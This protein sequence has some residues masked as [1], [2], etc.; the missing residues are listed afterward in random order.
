MTDT[1]SPIHHD[2]T[3]T[4]RE[5]IE[6]TAFARH[7]VT[8]YSAGRLRRSTLVQLRWAAV[9]GQ[10]L[11]MAIVWFGLGFTLP[12]I[13]CAATIGTSAVLNLAL[14][15][16]A[17]LDRRVSDKEALAQLAFDSLQLAALLWLTGGLDNPFALLFLAPVVTSATTLRKR[18]L[19]SLAALTALLAIFLMY[20]SLPLPWYADTDFTL[21]PMFKI[22]S[23]TALMT[24]MAFTSLYAWGASLEQRRMSDALAATEAVLA[25]EQKLAALGGLAAA[26]A[27]EL[28]TPLAT[29]QV[30]AKEMARELSADT[31]L[32]ADARLMHS[33]AMRCRDI[34]QQLARR[35]DEGDVIHDVFS[36]KALLDE[37]SEPFFGFGT[38]IDISV[39]GTPESG[40][41]PNLKRQAELIYGLTNIVENGVDFANH[42]VSITGRWDAKFIYVDI[43]DDG[44][45]FDAS[46]KSKLGEPYVSSRTDKSGA[47]G[48]GLGFFIAKTLIERTGGQVSF[49]NRQSNS[50]AFVRVR[51][52]RESVLA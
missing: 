39:S 5:Q 44:P 20:E 18:V 52:P 50:G 19:F 43:L 30:T 49:G 16:M 2:P 32:G 42:L 13:P 23:F 51:W 34:L 9:I 21:P 24:G 40:I 45:G 17:P 27:H 4:E 3:F 37:V 10:S 14:S 28:G 6:M 31:D 15:Y 12:I 1:P 22:G 33:Q 38:Q 26:A 48:L 8:P 7:A 25:Q 41:G 46:I 11:A 47:G 35:G 29:I 36:L